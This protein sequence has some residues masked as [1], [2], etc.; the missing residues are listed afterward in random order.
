MLY[1]LTTTDVNRQVEYADQSRAVDGEVR[2]LIERYRQAADVPNEETLGADLARDWEGYLEVRDRVI[3]EV[4][5]GIIPDATRDDL[6]LGVPTFNL[7]RD[8]LRRIKDSYEQDAARRVNALE[9]S[10]N[11]ALYRIVFILGLTQLFALAAG[12]AV[13]KSAARQRVASQMRLAKE[14][15]DDASRAKS[16][17]LANMSHEIRTPMNGIIGMTELAL[18]T[19]L[20]DEQRGCL[21]T[22]NAS[23]H[24]LLATLN[25]ILDFSKIESRKLELEVVPM[26]LHDLVDEVLKTSATSAHSKGLELVSDVA[27]DVP[28]SVL[29]D[30]VR[31]RQVLTNLVTNAIKFT[32]AGHVVV[33]VMSE[34]RTADRCTLRVSV[35][36]TGVG[37][38][39]D[40][41]AA[42]FEAF[43]QADGST[44]R[45][46]GGI[47]LG[48]AISAHLVQLMRGR[49][50]VES[51]PGKGSTFIFTVD[52]GIGS[53]P[54]AIGALMLAVAA[55]VVLSSLGGRLVTSSGPAGRVA[56]ALLLGA[57]TAAPAGEVDAA[58]RRSTAPTAEAG[59]AQALASDLETYLVQQGTSRPLVK[60]DQEAWGVAAGAIL[61]LQKRGTIVSVEEDWVVMF[62]PAFRATGREDAVITV[63]MPPE[64]LRLAARGVRTISSHGPIYA[65][66]ERPSVQ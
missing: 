26:A 61:A 13:Q 48:L 42:I 8:D 1:A 17:F 34:S 63:A 56:C 30:P 38:P 5:E 60:I 33:H 62:T 40:K 41:H 31:V 57:A 15:A 52:L 35:S 32:E 27:A 51:E 54:L 29:G 20:T 36:D 66:A 14:S 22:V 64:H 6:E 46:Y 37:I 7:V 49:I 24:N 59:V 53:V 45:R 16:E 44:T 58:A 12:S 9:R 25:D 11:L 18:D 47:G 4:L 39:P 19:D 28:T 10:S 21:D 2:A 55:D 65:H 43:R 50:W 3:S 23:A